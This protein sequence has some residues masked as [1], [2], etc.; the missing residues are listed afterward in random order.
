MSFK[1]TIQA[2]G[3]N[4]EA[5]LKDE[6]LISVIQVIQEK[7]DDSIPA[8]QA[9]PIKTNPKNLSYNADNSTVCIKRNVSTCHST[10][11]LKL[12]SV[13]GNLNPT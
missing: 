8:T 10:N 4:I 1:I 5:N 12:I 13:G 7:R 11:P 2:S 6:A 3:L 9:S